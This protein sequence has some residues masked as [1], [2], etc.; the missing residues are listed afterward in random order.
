[1]TRA[2]IIRAP[3]PSD[4]PTRPTSGHIPGEAGIWV[5]L[6]GDMPVFTLLFTVYMNRRDRNEA[7][8]AESHDHLNRTFGAINTLPATDPRLAALSAAHAEATSEGDR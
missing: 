7:L 1:M 2:A 6:F 3:H 8:F 4:T 5:L